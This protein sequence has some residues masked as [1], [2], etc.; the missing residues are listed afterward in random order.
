[1]DIVL[2]TF[3]F[4][5]GTTTAQALWMGVPTLTLTKA[6]ML[7]RQGEA[8]LVNACLF[9]WVAHSEDE[10]VEKAIAWGNSDAQKR[11]ELAMLR[12]TLREQVRQSPVFD[13]K[14][15]ASDFVDAMYGMW[16]EKCQE[17]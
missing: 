14:Q 6:G 10:Y 3:P 4:P 11:Q 7:G 13:A 9:D 12:A 17:K 5:G 16:R 8:L 2:D 1:V 15:F